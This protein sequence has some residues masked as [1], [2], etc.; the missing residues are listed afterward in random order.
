M[1]FFVVTKLSF[2]RLKLCYTPAHESCHGRD[3]GASIQAFILLRP[4]RLGDTVGSDT[5][6]WRMLERRRAEYRHC[7][8][9]GNSSMHMA[10]I[11]AKCESRS[12]GYVQTRLKDGWEYQ[13]TTRYRCHSSQ[14][15][16]DEYETCERKKHDTE[17]ANDAM[18]AR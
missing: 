13:G 5:L 12:S 17:Q 16:S 7:I 15:N 2:C 10:Q 11:V 6:Q 1:Q 9:A 4:Y 3:G 14:W 8:N 18:N